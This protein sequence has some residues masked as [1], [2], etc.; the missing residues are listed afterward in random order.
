MSINHIITVE[1]IIKDY[2]EQKERSFAYGKKRVDAEKE[3]NRLLTKYNG[4]SKTYSLEQANRIYKAH[5]DMIVFGEEAAIA[6]TRFMEAEE[7]LREAGRILFDASI[8]AEIRIAPLN[9][10]SP[11]IREVTV[12]FDNGSVIV[13]SVAV[14]ASI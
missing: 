3:Y 14:N 12:A 13:S 7:R 11:S 5:N 2:L 8:T 10:D 6:H 1:T 9:G 4:E